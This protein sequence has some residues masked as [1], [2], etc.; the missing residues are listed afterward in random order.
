M[1]GGE[2]ERDPLDASVKYLPIYTETMRRVR[3]V[4]TSKEKPH[5]CKISY[6]AYRGNE[7]GQ[8]NARRRAAQRH[9]ILRKENA[10]RGTRTKTGLD[11]DTA[12]YRGVAARCREGS[13]LTLKKGM[14]FAMRYDNRDTNAVS[15]AHRSLCI[16]SSPQTFTR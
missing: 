7:E 10:T 1:R 5:G 9:Q 6:F 8:R 13:R 15:I 4:V 3:E 12:R 14:P 16:P 11:L 2:E